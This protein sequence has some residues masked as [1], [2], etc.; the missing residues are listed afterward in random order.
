MSAAF[1]VLGIDPGRGGAFAVVD[2]D[3]HLIRQDKMPRE[4]DLAAAL[5]ARL[6]NE[7]EVSYIAI[8]RVTG[9]IPQKNI[10]NASRMFVMGW[11]TGGP[12]F[13]AYLLVGAKR[14]KKVMAH[15]WQRDLEI[16]AKGDKKIL[17]QAARNKFPDARFPQQV[18]DAILI[19]LW[20]VSH[21]QK[22]HENNCLRNAS[23]DLGSTRNGQPFKETPNKNDTM[24]T[25]KTAKKAAAKAPASGKEGFA[26][27]CNY[28]LKRFAKKLA[29]LVG[30]DD[31]AKVKE[32][33]EKLFGKNSYAKVIEASGADEATLAR[34]HNEFFAQFEKS[35]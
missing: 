9:W 32:L 29:G 26:I 7:A 17:V 21:F 4:E 6:V 8:E 34:A 1:R 35:K 10:F 2:S 11:W 23:A 5:M 18:A 14:V 33:R 30:A 25:K 16:S 27:D 20:A 13:A 3:G 24:A 28:I 31:R 15:K 22:I 19:A 12:L